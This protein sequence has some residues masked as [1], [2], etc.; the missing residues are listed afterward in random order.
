MKPPTKWIKFSK[1]K[2]VLMLIELRNHFQKSSRRKGTTDANYREK[3]NR[4]K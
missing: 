2:I 1:G 3:E 4:E